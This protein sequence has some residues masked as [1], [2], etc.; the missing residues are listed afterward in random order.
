MNLNKNGRK[1]LFC[2]TKCVI[3]GLLRPFSYTMLKQNP[4]SF[5][6]SKYLLEF[7]CRFKIFEIGWKTERSFS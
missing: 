6:T 3:H 5:H 1:E 2:L 7:S 4:D